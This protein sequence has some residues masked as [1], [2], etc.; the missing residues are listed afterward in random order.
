[1]TDC[2]KIREAFVTYRR[3]YPLDD[4][5]P[6]GV[7]PWREYPYFWAV[8]DH[9]GRSYPL[10]YI[11]SLVADEETPYFHTNEAGRI[12]NAC[13]YQTVQLHYGCAPG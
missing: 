12:M 8:L 13:G 10:K 5:K 7:L 1:M 3:E 11:Y 4:Y 9:S 2:E 6:R